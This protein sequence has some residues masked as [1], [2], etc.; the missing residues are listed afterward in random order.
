MNII[1]PQKK[2]LRVN[3]IENTQMTSW[4]LNNGN[5]SE[6]YKFSQLSLEAHTYL[7]MFT[8]SSG[9]SQLSP[10]V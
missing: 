1:I 10:D 5:S 7:R 2:I 9:F 8:P 4:Y 6:Q 3:G